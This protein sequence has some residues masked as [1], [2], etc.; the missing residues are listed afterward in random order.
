M[1]SKKQARFEIYIT[2]ISQAKGKNP[3]KHK[4]RPIY[5]KD[6]QSING[7]EWQQTKHCKSGP[8]GVDSNP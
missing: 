8:L 1:R 3:K 2:V 6:N 5:Q 4:N 7:Y